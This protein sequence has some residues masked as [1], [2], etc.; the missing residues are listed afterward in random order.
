[1]LMV[2]HLL[3]YHP[4][5]QY[6]KKMVTEKQIGDLLYIYCQRVNLG[7]VRKDENAL[8]SFAPH[9]LSV[10]LHLM[11][12]E[13]VDVA[14]RGAAFLQPDVEDVVFVDLRFP[15]G[16]TAHVHV[17]WLDPHKLRKFTVVGTQK[18][19]V[20]DDM[21][22]SEKIK[23][24]DKGVDRAAQVV[25]YGDALTVRSGDILIPKISLQEPLKLECAHFVECVR[26]RKRPLTDGLGGLRVVKVL[27]AAQRSLKNGGTPVAIAPLPLEVA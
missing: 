13:P 26:D 12:Q 23:V 24:Y 10:I 16:Q 22:A 11:D 15:S 17:S 9:D 7:K 14:A 20:F 21:E 4:G 25:S 27:D 2:G 19:M 6:L 1:V 3:L 18:M 5:V 8:W